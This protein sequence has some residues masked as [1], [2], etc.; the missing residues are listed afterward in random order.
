MSRSYQWLIALEPPDTSAMPSTVQTTSAVPGQ[1]S[2]RERQRAD[3]RDD[4]Q[5]HDA[6]LEQLPVVAQRWPRALF[7]GPPR[8]RDPSWR[9]RWSRRQS[10]PGRALPARTAAGGQRAHAQSAAHA[11]RCC[12][13]DRWRGSSRRSARGA[14]SGA[15]GGSRRRSCRRRSAMRGRPARPLPMSSTEAEMRTLTPTRVRCGARRRTVGAWL[16]TRSVSVVGGDVA[17]LVGG[18]EREGVRARRRAR[19][20]ASWPAGRRRARA[21]PRA[22]CRR[23]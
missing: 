18:D 7:P 22:A 1:P 10:T 19:R 6:R 16:S 21:S 8:E 3:R 11:R 5:Q 20:S 13:R 23:P 9:R 14:C 15:R 12:P 4:D 2:R 17:A